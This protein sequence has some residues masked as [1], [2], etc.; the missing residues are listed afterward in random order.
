MTNTTNAIAYYRT[1]SQ[2]GVG[3]DKDSETRQRRAVEQYATREGL[4][5]VAEYYDA[6]VSG[7]DPVTTREA[8]QRMM[9]ERKA[10][11]ILVETANRFARDLIVQLTGHE[12]LL[13]AG[14]TLIPVDA[15]N[16]FL[17]DT[18]TARL[19]RQVLG[20]VSEFEKATI[21]ARMH[22]GRM[23]RIREQ[24]WCGGQPAIP[25]QVK[26]RMRAIRATGVSYRDV[27]ARLVGE[28]HKRYDPKTIK[29]V[30][31]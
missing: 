9:E 1:S 16:H 18:P 8:F 13:E 27:A 12:M 3:D 22:S 23:K 4:V 2:A 21:T 25:A 5:I 31:G 20:A 14:F 19:I 30:C 10:N 24:G 28:G 17:E 15:P 6:A 29:R 11:V 7:A 26:E